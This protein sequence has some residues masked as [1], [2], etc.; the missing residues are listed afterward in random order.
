[1]SPQYFFNEI[2]GIKFKKKNIL[3]KILNF[4]NDLIKI[5]FSKKKINMI[6][7]HKFCNKIV[8]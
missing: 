3:T 2:L 6:I 1:M 8:F 4:Q 5:T 7:I